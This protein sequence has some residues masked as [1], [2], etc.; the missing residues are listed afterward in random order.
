MRREYNQ[1][2]D[3]VFVN[4]GEYRTS[5]YAMDDGFWVTREKAQWSGDDEIAWDQCE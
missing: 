3:E 5:L 1:D 2:G 4:Y